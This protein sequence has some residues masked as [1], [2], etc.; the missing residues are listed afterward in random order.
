LFL[1]KTIF[2]RGSERNFSFCHRI[3]VDPETHSASYSV[4][5]GG[6]FPGGKAAGV[7]SWLLTSIYCRG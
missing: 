5:T 7:W 6:S 2:D 3:Q 1:A 4:S